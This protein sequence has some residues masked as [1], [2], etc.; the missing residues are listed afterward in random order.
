[1]A[2][3]NKCGAQLGPGMTFC[4]ACGA[5]VGALAGSQAAP[6]A[7]GAI[8]S[9]VAALLAYV[10]GLVTGIIFLVL[11][12]YKNDKFVRFHAFQ[13][14]FFN[15]AV[16]VFWIAYNIVIAILAHL[17]FGILGIVGWFLGP[18]IGLAVFAYWLFLMF[19]AYNNQRYVIPF[20][21]QF[22][23]KQAG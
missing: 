14:I 10:F 19:K 16:I 1:M 12:P 8:T 17:S 20:V 5:A 11:E 3:C 15:I 2:F 21:G 18:V 9:N 7:C 22:A 23:E 6:A 4:G 13:S